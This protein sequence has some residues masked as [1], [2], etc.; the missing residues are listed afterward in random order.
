MA[1]R[2]LVGEEVQN[3]VIAKFPVKPE[4]LQETGQFLAEIL[5]GTRAFKGCIKLDLYLEEAT[6][7]YILVEYWDSLANYDRYVEW[8]KSTGTF[9]LFESLI[10]GG[11]AGIQMHKCGEVIGRY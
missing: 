4:K 7:T 9:D 10:V 11:T 3:L 8:R 6:K 1:T 2:I 5:P